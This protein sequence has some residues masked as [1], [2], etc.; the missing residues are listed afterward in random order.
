MVCLFH[1]WDW[2][3]AEQALDSARNFE[4]NDAWLIF[5]ERPGSNKTGIRKTLEEL[6]SVISLDPVNLIFLSV[7]EEICWWIRDYQQ[8]MAYA[9]Q[10]LDLDRATSGSFR[11]CPCL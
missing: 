11:S 2:D 6:R 1:D 7:A 5:I 9:F 10:A 3:R 8:A 4:P